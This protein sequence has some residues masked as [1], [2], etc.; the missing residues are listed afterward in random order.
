MKTA[1]EQLQF[2]TELVNQ[3]LILQKALK[4]SEE[5]KASMPV[6]MGIKGEIRG[7]EKTLKWFG[8]LV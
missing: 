4:Q 5:K 6:I 1:E 7:V 3:Y 2:L 8:I